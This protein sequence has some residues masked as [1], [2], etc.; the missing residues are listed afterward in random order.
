MR[1]RA[2]VLVISYS[3]FFAPLLRRGPYLLKDMSPTAESLRSTIRQSERN[4]QIL[5]FLFLRPA[6][7]GLG[8]CAR[9]AL[10]RRG[11]KSGGIKS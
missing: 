4:E 1:G 3:A 8:V 10:K 9:N 11:H 5:L 6:R 7:P 2:N